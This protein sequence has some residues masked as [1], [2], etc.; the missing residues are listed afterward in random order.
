MMDLD[1]VLLDDPAELEHADSGGMLR[2]VA[3]AGAQ[4]RTAA[5]L[6]AELDIDRLGG[7]PRAVVIAGVG[8]SAVA[9]DVVSAV[10]GTSCGVPIEVVRS[11]VLPGW[12]GA[13]DLVV[14]LSASGRTAEPAAVAAEAARRGV[15]LLAVCR[16]GSRL[17]DTVTYAGGV[18]AAVPEGHSPRSSLWSLA[19]PALTVAER[20][21]VLTIPHGSFVAAADRL[22]ADAIRCRP[23]SEA[24]VNPAKELALALDGAL[25]IVWG[26]AGVAATAAY[27]FV[28][29]LA[30]NAKAP[31]IYGA[32]PE[33]AHNA[34]VT[35]D[36]QWAGAAEDLFADEPG[37]RLRL[38]LLRDPAED[39]AIAATA[40]ACRTV[41]DA[42]GV[43]AT[44]L[45]AEGDTP[46]ERLASLVGP[47]D[48]ASVY[49]ALAAR[50]DPTPITA[51][52]DVKAE[53]AP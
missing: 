28:C 2:A 48:F 26:T 27:R 32:L 47:L 36:G 15:P 5:A 14:V 39:A 12:V 3:T 40:D 13:A 18:V 53:L 19:V 6:S 9:G 43:R 37:P 10:A 20:L 44:E 22:D 7:R 35:F 4:V 29:Q 50:I 51:I 45:V 49:L 25:P 42:R 33:A 8:G 46:L 11:P 52:D 16:A 1:E 30:E 21:G 34:V 17:A 24:F 31:A 23:S 41:A 38:L